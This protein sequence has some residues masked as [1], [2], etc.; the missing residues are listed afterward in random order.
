M[1]TFQRARSDEARE[2][3]RQAIL[4]TTAEMLGEL[5][6]GDITLN[7]ISR[8][9]Q[10]AKSSILKYF[11]SRE[12]ILLELLDGERK[13]WLE[14]LANRPGAEGAALPDRCRHLADV[15]THSLQP[16]RVLCDLLSAQ[17]GVLEHNVSADVAARY[18][19]AAITDVKTLAALTREH[20]PELDPAGAVHLCAAV[21]MTIGAV[22]SHSQPA[23]GMLAAYRADPALAAYRMDFAQTLHGILSLLITGA[24]A[25]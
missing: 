11:D 23:A 9:G 5:S 12:A 10:L 13:E 18:K 24:T 1:T 21:T 3:R 16:R 17:A 25:S 19:Q 4:R 14:D 15:L 20:L 8:R 6:V 7:E 2:I 22:W